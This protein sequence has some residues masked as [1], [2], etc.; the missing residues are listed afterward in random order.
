VG[1]R[2]GKL[3]DAF[4]MLAKVM[5]RGIRRGRGVPSAEFIPPMR[6]HGIVQPLQRE[7]PTQRRRA[8]SMFQN[9]RADP[10]T[11]VGGLPHGTT[12]IHIRKTSPR[13]RARVAD[14]WEGRLRGKKSQCS[15]I[16]RKCRRV[17]QELKFFDEQR[18]SA[19][20]REAAVKRKRRGRAARIP[21][22]PKWRS[23]GSPRCR[24][25][26]DLGG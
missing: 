5:N 16:L 23:T 22:T 13:S 2:Y 14:L 15:T 4:R 11:S 25:G 3:R 26:P 21:Q 20:L 1:V 19:E 8:R 18:G 24:S 10:Q 12:G 6:R 9:H 7:W 17:S